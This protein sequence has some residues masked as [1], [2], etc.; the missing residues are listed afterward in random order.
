MG[1]IELIKS[2]LVLTANLVSLFSEIWLTIIIIT[3]LKKNIKLSNIIEYGN[4]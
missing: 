3:F 4:K 2:I 1:W